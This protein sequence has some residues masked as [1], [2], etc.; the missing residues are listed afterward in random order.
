MQAMEDEHARID[1]LLDAVGAALADTANGHQRLGDTVD[2][3]V[4]ELSGH[5]AHEE[6]DTLP[7]LGRTLTR[8]EWQGVRRRPAAQERHPRRRS[9]VPVAAR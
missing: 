4:T 3:L 2:T 6:R 7:L 1:P 9:A 8:A 5:L